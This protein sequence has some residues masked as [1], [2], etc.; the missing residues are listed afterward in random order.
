M[1]K[2]EKYSSVLLVVLVLL[3]LSVFYGKILWSPNSYLFGISG[4]GMKNYF[5]YV[6]QIR[7]YAYTESVAMNYPYGENFL[8]LDCQPSFTM[9]IKT[10]SKLFPFIAEN[11]IGIVNFLLIFS[12]GISA[13]FLYLILLRFSVRP[14][15]SVI[16]AISI[17]ILAPQIFRIDGHLALGYSCFIPISWY[18][19]LRFNESQ[20]KWKWSILMCVNTL[21]WFFT[22][23][24]LGMI[25]ATFIFICF[26]VDGI[27]SLGKKF[28]DIRFLG[29]FFIQTIFPVLFFWGYAK[30]TD[31][32]TGRTNNPYGFMESS[33]NFDS[34]FYPNHEPLKPWIEQHTNL[35]Q[36]WEGWAYIGIGSVIGIVSFIL[37]FLY[38]LI[39]NR[40]FSF[41]ESGLPKPLLISMIAAIIVLLISFGYPFKWGT[42]E[43]WLDK[44]SVIKNF[45]GIGRFAWVFFYVVTI[46]VISFLFKAFTSQKIPY[47][48]FVLVIFISCSFIYEGIPYHRGKVESL[49]VFPNY[50]DK[51]QLSIEFKE[52]LRNID[53]SN[54]QAIVP[55]PYYHIGSENFGKDATDK[56]YRISMLFGYHSGLPILSNYSTRTSI[57]ESKNIMQVISPQFYKKV[58]E[59]DIKDKRPFIVIYS[60]EDL[61]EC[62]RS[63]LERSKE[64]YK[65]SEYTLLEI[66]RE[67]LLSYKTK[68]WIN[69]FNTIEKD[70]IVKDGFWVNRS[71]DSTYLY[72]EPYEDKTEKIVF[73]GK[74]A[75][76][77]KKKDYTILKEFEKD[78]LKPNHEYIASFWMYNNGYNYGQDISNGLLFYQVAHQ[79]GRLEWLTM[80]NVSAGL[81]INGDWSL[82]E[83]R[84]KVPENISHS[85]LT[86]KG[87]DRSKIIW[88]VDDLLI[89]DADVDV[90]KVL[91]GENPYNKLLFMNNHRIP[92]SQ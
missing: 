32:H 6:S 87:D 66:S 81:N 33:S 44:F 80:Q 37:F 14:I 12:I 74:G 29:Y 88:Y 68:A 53:F 27:L 58:I 92:F 91:S 73:N 40:R 54:Y 42:M 85:S 50:F 4:D 62:E 36:N 39:K 76:S 13:W 3:F 51:N 41:M 69:H 25:I 19:Y 83:I 77:C 71:G 63:I 30:F 52:G 15:L 82:I 9:I 90:Y 67:E 55:L 47:L 79:D 78:E 28:L 8:Y 17:A 64:L 72:Y 86:L 22:H 5:T 11:S 61:L 23:A 57:W 18:L 16:A 38:R 1:E 49:T 24:Y 43:D 7:S 48:P 84:F 59:G 35:E 45:R 34:V 89:R 65:N 56:I 2:I 75:R 31:I 10:L 21:F 60:H 70:L 46:A 20:K 26:V